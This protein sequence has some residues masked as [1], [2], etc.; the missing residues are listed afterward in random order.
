MLKFLKKEIK[1]NL[2]ITSIL[3]GLSALSFLLT[4]IG[5]ENLESDIVVI[6]SSLV[7]IICY[8]SIVIFII[9]YFRSDF[10]S[11][12]GYLTYTL[13]IKKESIMLSKIIY[14]FLIA[15]IYVFFIVLVSVLYFIPEIFKSIT[16]IE[17][18]VS[19]TDFIKII[20]ISLVMLFSVM[21][22][23]Y[24]SI[25]FTKVLNLSKKGYEWICVLIII[26]FAS[27]KIFTSIIN[28]SYTFFNFKNDINIDLIISIIFLILLDV[29]LFFTTKKALNKKLCI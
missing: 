21:Q 16:E 17:M 6:L 7:F 10:Y 2:K 24:S 11:D 26:S 27:V 12:K 29:L 4:I 13:P 14:G 1:D 23:L 22:M 3:L 15:L 19:L 9:I 28:F 8:Y 5:S 25:A 20:S 18:R